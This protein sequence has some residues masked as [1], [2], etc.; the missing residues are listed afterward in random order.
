MQKRVTAS[1]VAQ[2]LRKKSDVIMYDM[3]ESV[4]PYARKIKEFVEPSVPDFVEAT[5]EFSPDSNNV[6]TTIVSFELSYSSKYD[7][8]DSGMEYS[9][10]WGAVESYAWENNKVLFD[11]RENSDAPI[12]IKTG[13]YSRDV[14]DGDLEGLADAMISVLQE[15]NLDALEG[16]QD[17][18]EEIVYEATTTEEERYLTKDYIRDMH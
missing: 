6:M 8:H 3:D 9:D 16:M 15:I 10:V 17:V 11:V 4:E 1:K 5:V 18:Y 14:Q 2:I 13:V 7:Q 12:D